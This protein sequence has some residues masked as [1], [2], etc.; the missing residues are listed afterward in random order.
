MA[1]DAAA[2][3]LVAATRLVAAF[4]SDNRL[5]PG[6]PK[7]T[8]SS[9]LEVGAEAINMLV[10]RAEDLIDDGATVRLV[11]F[12][13]GLTTAEQQAWDTAKGEL[14]SSLAVPR[15]S[16]LG[17]DTELLHALVRDGQLV[18]VRDDLVYLP[19]QVDTITDMLQRLEDGFTVAEFRDEIGVTRRQAVPLLEWFDKQGTTV[20]RGDGRVVKKSG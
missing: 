18:R 5:R 16:A 13:P 20:R 7:A 19:E 2:D 17:L 4:H 11:S 14:R 15:A 8:L 10:S 12:Q 3:L 1:Q 6:M 9:S